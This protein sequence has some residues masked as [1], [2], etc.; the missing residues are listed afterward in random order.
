MEMNTE[1]NTRTPIMLMSGRLDTNAEKCE[2]ALAG[3]I[4]VRA[5]VLVRIG[6]RYD[7][8]P[9]EILDVTAE[10]LRR[11]LTGLLDFLTPDNRAVSGWRRADC[12]QELAA[13][14]VNTG[15]WP[16]LRPLSEE[17]SP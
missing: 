17:V 9:V 3:E 5:G 7:G 1:A 11:R 6:R 2:Q 8:A 10:W 13:H 16:K 4:Y 12:P 14:I 15:A